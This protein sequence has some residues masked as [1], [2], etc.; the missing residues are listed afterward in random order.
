MKAPL[1]KIE[2]RMYNALLNLSARNTTK[3]WLAN[4]TQ[5]EFIVLEGRKRTNAFSGRLTIEFKYI[6]VP[7]P[8]QVSDILAK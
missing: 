4:R 3:T 6:H 7:R 1:N 5:K 2:D 8:N